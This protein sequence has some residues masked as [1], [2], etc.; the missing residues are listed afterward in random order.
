MSP[1]GGWLAYSTYLGGSSIELGS[2]I[3]VDSAGFAYVAGY[4]YSSDFPTTSG[5]YDTSYN[6]G[7]SEAFLT[8]VAPG[9]G[10]LASSTY[11]GGSEGESANSI[12]IDSS[13]AAYVAGLTRSAD[14]PTTQALT[15]PLTT[16]V[17]LTP[18]S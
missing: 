7:F 14:F 16:A 18:S 9:G 10:A 12:A 13:G 15:T 4:T 5:A 8:K 17:P 3:A 11:L 1:G 2:A 6:G